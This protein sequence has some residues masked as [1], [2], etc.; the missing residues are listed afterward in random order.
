LKTP[1]RFHELVLP[2]CFFKT[3]H[4]CEEA[5]AGSLA[6][7]SCTEMLLERKYPH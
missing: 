6:W 7:F 1:L 5:L 2:K 4:L 3:K